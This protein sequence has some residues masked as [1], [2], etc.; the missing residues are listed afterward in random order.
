MS[1]LLIH[2]TFAAI[3]KL[4]NV[5][6]ITGAETLLYEQYT[7][8]N[9]SNI[10]AR[11]AP[12]FPRAIW[13]TPCK[14]RYERGIANYPSVRVRFSVSDSHFLQMK[15]ILTN[16]EKLEFAENLAFSFWNRLTDIQF[17]G[18]TLTS[19]IADV[20]TEQYRDK[21]NHHYWESL[22]TFG[23]NC[24]EVCPQTD[25]ITPQTPLPL[26]Y[27]SLAPTFADIPTDIDMLN[28]KHYP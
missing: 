3:C 21:N 11:N 13:I 14:T 9:S 22:V 6:Y 20:Q 24:K 16:S 12:D 27:Q 5:N 15:P 19:T 7:D 23:I 18:F 8:K 10:P 17:L 28:F 26:L 2:N 4:D 1:I 25:T